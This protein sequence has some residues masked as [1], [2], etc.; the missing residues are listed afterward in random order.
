MRSRAVEALSSFSLNLLNP[1]SPS[2][3]LGNGNYK[4]SQNSLNDFQ[5]DSYNLSGAKRFS[6]KKMRGFLKHGGLASCKVSAET[7][8]LRML[9]S[10][11]SSDF[12]DSPPDESTF[13]PQPS[14][15]SQQC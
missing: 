4:S 5:T 7:E 8:T 14:Y 9:R 10:I 13:G 15:Q 1:D 12:R 3:V 11:N 2:R 6:C